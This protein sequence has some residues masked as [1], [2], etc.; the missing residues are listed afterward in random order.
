M[1]KRDKDFATYG[2]EWKLEPVGGTAGDRQSMD[3]RRSLAAV[4]SSVSSPTSDLAERLFFLRRLS[5]CG[6]FA[7]TWD[8]NVLRAQTQKDK[9]LFLHAC[10]HVR[11]R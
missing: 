10:A 8:P 6:R 2:Q 5:L 7:T 1:Q 3:G 4:L 11:F 9:H